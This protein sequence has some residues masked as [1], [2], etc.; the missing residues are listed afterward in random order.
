MTTYMVTWRY[1]GQVCVLDLDRG[2]DAHI[3]AVA[4]AE[5]PGRTEVR[6]TTVEG[7]EPDEETMERIRRRVME[8]V[9]LQEA[10]RAG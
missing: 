5:L 1:R 4:L 3:I 7:L 8:R 9:R 10:L 2:R 6:L